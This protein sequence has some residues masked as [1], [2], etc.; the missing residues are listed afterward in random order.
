MSEHHIYCCAVFLHHIYCCAV[1]ISILACKW[2]GRG[3]LQT[4]AAAQDR[5]QI[6]RWWKTLCQRSHAGLIDQIDQH[7][8]SGYVILAHI[9]DFVEVGWT[10]ALQ[11]IDIDHKVLNGLRLIKHR[12]RVQEGNCRKPPWGSQESSL[13]LRVKRIL[14]VTYCL[15]SH[16]VWI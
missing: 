13:G 14:I 12:V 5:R 2:E 6:G 9:V 4:I 16:W 7:G 8:L 11:N 15:G 1:F 10:S 3:Y